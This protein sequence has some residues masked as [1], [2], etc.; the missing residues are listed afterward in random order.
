MK[1]T[2]THLQRTYIIRAFKGIDR[3]YLARKLIKSGNRNIVDRIATGDMRVSFQR[4]KDIEKITFG[5]V[6][7]SILRPD[8]YGKNL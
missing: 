6:K 2:L 1:T 8:I 7:A 5:R 4:A 3:Q